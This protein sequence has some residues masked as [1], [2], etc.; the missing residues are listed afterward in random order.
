MRTIVLASAVALC[1]AS[2]A[3][4][5]Y[6]VDAR[7]Q[8]GSLGCN[9]LTV[10]QDIKA[11]VVAPYVEAVSDLPAAGSFASASANLATGELKL[12][13]AT[14]P[15]ICPRAGASA[16]LKDLLTFD[17]AGGGSAAVTFKFDIDGTLSGKEPIS[18]QSS[19]TFNIDGVSFGPT[20]TIPIQDLLTRSVTYTRNVFDG[21]QVDIQVSMT[22]ALQSFPGIFDLSHT[23]SVSLVLPTGVTFLSD[24]GVFLTAP[25]GG[26]V[27]EPASW[28]LMI[29]GF[30]AAGGTLRRR[31]AAIGQRS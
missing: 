16:T 2:S 30:A 27:P 26:G 31:Q 3:Q 8:A 23:G 9:P 6:F 21:E 10:H 4:A 12:Y 19:Y 15:G 24:S 13:G 20:G 28:A 5:A 11:F 17:V 1:S 14:G 25:S 22:A 7:T 18:T 29:V